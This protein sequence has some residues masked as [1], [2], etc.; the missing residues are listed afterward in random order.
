[1]RRPIVPALLLALP[2]ALAGCSYFR[3]K[4]PTYVVFFDQGSVTLDEPAR[5]AVADAARGANAAPS[6]PVTVSSYIGATAATG[7]NEVERAQQRADAVSA[8]LVTDGVRAD[9]LRRVPPSPDTDTPAGVASRRVEID[10]K[11]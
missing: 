2:I 1:M 6:L 11:R 5:S 4:A 7:S 8:L 10:V 9:R 3:P